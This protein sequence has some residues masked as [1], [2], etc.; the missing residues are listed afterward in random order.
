[1]RQGILVHIFTSYGLSLKTPK[2]QIES[3]VSQLPAFGILPSHIFE[4][5][6]RL[7]LF[8][9]F[10]YPSFS[11]ITLSAQDNIPNDYQ[12]PL[13][14]N[15]SISPAKSIEIFGNLRNGTNNQP[16]RVTSLELIKLEGG[17][18]VLQRMSQAGPTFRFAPITSLQVPHLIKA[19]YQ[20][21]SYTLLIPPSKDF[22]RKK[23]VLTVYESGAA[24][25]SLHVHVAVSVTKKQNSLYVEKIFAL[26]N[27]SSPPRS[28]FLEKLRFFI[29]GNARELQASLRYRKKGSMPLPLPLQKTRDGYYYA[30]YGLRP[31]EAELNLRYVVMGHLLQDSLSK[32]SQ[33][34]QKEETR[35]LLWQPRAAK[36]KIEATRF[37]L[38]NVPQVGTAYK[39]YYPP[40]EMVNYDFSLGDFVI[41]NPLESDFNPIF[42]QAVKTVIALLLLVA[43]FFLITALIA[44]RVYVNHK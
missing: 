19:V 5:L 21:T 39:V 4:A 31:G 24:P 9:V 12:K 25:S 44:K 8:F 10:Y 11:F 22:W 28:F 18:N 3:Q 32:M 2:V 15:A 16:V 29:P 7:L 33:R 26:Q 13:Q 6:A 41:D 20:G 30:T 38:I 17:M 40:N 36:P 34:S 27:K 1:M 43:H 35:V 42:N 23:Q 37:E 14:A